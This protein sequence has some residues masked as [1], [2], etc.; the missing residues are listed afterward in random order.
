VQSKSK[1]KET[2][3]DFTAFLGLVEIFLTVKS[4]LA[5]LKHGDFT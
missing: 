5:T 3:P 1:Q 4:Q 2:R